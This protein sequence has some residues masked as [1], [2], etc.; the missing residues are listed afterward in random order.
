MGTIRPNLCI[1]L[2][3]DEHVGKFNIKILF[4]KHINT[5]IGN[6]NLETNY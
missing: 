2:T 1:N 3:Q 4:K 5:D 6:T